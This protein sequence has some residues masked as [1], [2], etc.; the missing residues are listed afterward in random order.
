MPGCTKR[1][2]NAGRSNRTPSR[3][4]KPC[5][6]SERGRLF[7]EVIRLG[8]VA[9]VSALL[10]PAL[11]SCASLSLGWDSPWL[12][13]HQQPAPTTRE[14]PAD[15]AARCSREPTTGGRVLA[16]AIRMIEQ[17]TVIV[18]A[19]WDYVNAVFTRAGFPAAKRVTIYQATERGPFAAPALL[20]HGDWI[21]FVNHT[22]G[23]VGHS[24]IF[25]DW[26]D[27]GEQRALTVEYV[28]GNRHLP[29]RYAEYD[30]AECYGVFRG[31][32]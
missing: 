6:G 31:R 17:E 22:F 1:R 29:G 12:R 2:G 23:D 32:E 4:T 25:V 21:Y 18:G 16:M 14:A 10:L 28:G 9:I 5:R 7:L 24:A 20:E 15:T 30:I 13:P 11:S 8:R 3:A 27:A 26:I 19:C